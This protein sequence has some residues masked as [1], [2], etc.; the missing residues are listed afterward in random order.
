MPLEQRFADYDRFACCRPMR[1]RT[2]DERE[3]EREC[4]DAY[5]IYVRLLRSSDDD[6]SSSEHA[7]SKPSVLAILA[8]AAIVKHSL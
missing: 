8:T 7:L 4:N 6:K 2:G 5:L 1:S 3:R